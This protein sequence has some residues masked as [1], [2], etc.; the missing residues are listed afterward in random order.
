VIGEG[1]GVRGKKEDRRQKTEDREQNK[2]SSRGAVCDPP[3][4]HQE[5]VDS[6]QESVVSSKKIEA[7]KSLKLHSTKDIIKALAS[8]FLP[9]KIM[10]TI[11]PQRWTDNYFLWIKELIWQNVKNGVKYFLV[12]KK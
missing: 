8:D 9:D 3:V 2:I 6:S 1:L 12:Q 10:L 7:F 4:L 11:H 5:I